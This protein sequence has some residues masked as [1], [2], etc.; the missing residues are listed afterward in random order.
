METHMDSTTV[1][2]WMSAIKDV[3]R[4][5]SAHRFLQH[6]QQSVTVHDL[7]PDA[8]P[9]FGHW[10]SIILLAGQGIRFTFKVHYQTK[11]V[12]TLAKSIIS[13]TDHTE[14]LSKA[15]DFMREYCNLLAGSLKASLL[16][17]EVDL[18]ISLPIVIRG[19]DD[20][21]SEKK[22]SSAEYFHDSWAL[23]AESGK[24]ICVLS[25]NVYANQLLD[26]LAKVTFNETTQDEASDMEFL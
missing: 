12:M 13:A 26:R 4:R 23:Q 8:G 2:L 5:V 24:V 3:V 18:G 9:V 17:K 21:F 15:A 19:F 16:E 7:P 6:S 10:M 22:R 20:V 1:A 14:E 11:E 25:V